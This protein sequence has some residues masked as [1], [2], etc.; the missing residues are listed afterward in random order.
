M[1]SCETRLCLPFYTRRQAEARGSAEAEWCSG[2]GRAGAVLFPVD[3][4]KDAHVAVL[5]RGRHGALGSGNCLLL[6]SLQAFF[7]GILTP[8]RRE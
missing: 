1:G 5:R 6:L 4:I 2:G 8:W 3:K 7:G